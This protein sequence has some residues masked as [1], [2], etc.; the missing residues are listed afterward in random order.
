MSDPVPAQ[1]ASALFARLEEEM[2]R[3]PFHAILRPE[4]HEVN[5][6]TG[7]VVIRLQF[8]PEFSMDPVV[9]A[10]H[11]GVI[12]TLIDLA[13]HAAVATRLG[14]PAPTIDL[15]ID[16]L[17]PA[18]AVTL[19]ARA[20]VL[21]AGRSVAR[22]DVEIVADGKLVAVGRGTFSAST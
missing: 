5:A 12:A 11:G 6:E 21:R 20:R 4:A 14:R 2:R 22:A 18:P 15:R 13:G 1:P 7:E 19:F 16:Y 8:R 10:Y 17:R 9:Q 3:P